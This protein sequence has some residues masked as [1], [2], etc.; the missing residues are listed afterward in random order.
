MIWA[1]FQ[2]PI[3]PAM[4]AAAHRRPRRGCSSFS[5]WRASGQLRRSRTGAGATGDPGRIQANAGTDTGRSA[6]G[7][8][9]RSAGRPAVIGGG[10]GQGA[11]DNRGS[12]CRAG[13]PA[14]QAAAGVEADAHDP[15]LHPA[16]LRRRAPAQLG[17]GA[18]EGLRGRQRPLLRLPAHVRRH[19][20]AS[21]PQPTWPSATWR[22][23]CRQ[24]GATCPAIPA[25]TPHH[26]SRP[27]S[28]HAGYDACSVASNHS[29]DQ[30]APGVA[31]TLAVLDRAGLRHAGMARSPREARPRLLTVR[32]VRVALLSYTYGLNGFR[33]PRERPWLV[34]LLQPGRVLADARAARRAGSQFTVVFL[35]WGQEYRSAPTQAQRTPGCTAACRSRRRPHRRPPRP[36]GA[37]GAAHPRQVGGVRHGQLPVGPVGS[38]LSRGHPGR[39][40]RSRSPSPTRRAASSWSRSAT[41]RP[42]WSIPATA[43]FLCPGRLRPVACCGPRC[44]APPR[45]SGAPLAR[46]PGDDHAAD[47]RPR[48]PGRR[49]SGLCPGPAA[50]P[51]PGRARTRRSRPATSLQPAKAPATTTTADRRQ[52]EPGAPAAPGGGDPRQHLAQ[53]GRGVGGG[54]VI[55]QNM[56][57]RHSITVYDRS[58]RLVKT[59]SDRVT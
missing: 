24:P 10:R 4:H 21:C 23:R 59:I 13:G 49:A 1:A 16:G 37:A 58:Y 36:C 8:R 29:M 44:G 48:G 26:S 7:C 2:V 41:P 42:G 53:V 51:P 43:S 31:G 25:S 47:P 22:R 6:G 15:E 40:A 28:A 35:H 3:A 54:H 11:A 9:G 45:T 50:P 30:G 14:E 20:T 17:G 19:P 33:L 57:Y 38:L 46:R 52:A 39:R 32:G 55:A 18:G 12:A 56:M 34:N 5:S 27:P